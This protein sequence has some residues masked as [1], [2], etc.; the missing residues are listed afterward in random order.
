MFI[1]HTRIKELA[2]CQADFVSVFCKRIEGGTERGPNCHPHLRLS[3]WNLIVM[4][5]PRENGKE[6]I[7][8]DG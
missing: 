8:A 3:D 6:D 1:Q 4:A 7:Q 5:C 2:S